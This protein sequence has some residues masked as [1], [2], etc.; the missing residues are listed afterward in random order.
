M[1]GLGGSDA[2]N[3]VANAAS[4]PWILV[5]EDEK[6]KL[7][8]TKPKKT[9]GKEENPFDFSYMTDIGNWMKII[10]GEDATL[11]TYELPSLNID[12]KYYTVLAV[13]FVGPVP[14]IV[15]GYGSITATSPLRL[16]T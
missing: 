15:D 4:D 11:F 13:L 14:L 8:A 12:F 6:E 5:D 1:T 2:G 3:C 7:D 16:P 10:G 9:D